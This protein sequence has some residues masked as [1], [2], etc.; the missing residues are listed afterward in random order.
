M[1][2]D[3]LRPYIDDFLEMYANRPILKNDG[4]MKAPHC[5]WTYYWLRKVQP[6]VVIES[7]VFKGLSTWLIE[8]TCPNARVIAI[9]VYFGGLIYKSSKAEYTSVDFNSIDWTQVLGGKKT[10]AFIDDHQNNYERLRH[11][12]NHKIQYMIFEDNYPTSHG[13]V[14]SL[15]KIMMGNSYVIDRDGVKTYHTIPPEYKVNVMNVARY[16][17]CPPIYL[18]SAM[19]R[20]NDPFSIHQT[21][22][23]VFSTLEEGMDIFKED[24]L[25]YTFIAFVILNV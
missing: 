21:Q 14:L 25:D 4:G 5:F 24:Q 18:D 23:P 17:E 10:L 3:D 9:D 15:K 11:A 12:F 8:Q 13:D 20:W 16:M 22:P 2:S 6:E 19:T 1:N 7:G